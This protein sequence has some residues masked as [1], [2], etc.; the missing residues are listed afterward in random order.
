M[1]PFV[2]PDKIVIYRYPQDMRCGIQRLSEIVAAEM[3]LD[4]MDGGI[5]VFVSR[6]CKKVKMIK[7]EVSGWV[8]YYV[9]A[10]EG[11]FKWEHDEEGELTLAA[12][13]RQLLWLLEGL[14]I[15]QPQAPEPVTAHGIL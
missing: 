8:L 9:K 1:N 15:N 6:D 5:Y 13:R 11:G 7:F 2:C 4:A 12:E 10:V 3:E 14:P